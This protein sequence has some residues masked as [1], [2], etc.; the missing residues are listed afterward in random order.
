M[1]E[2]EAAQADLKAPGMAGWWE[3][4]IPKLSDEQASSL[5]SAAL[6]RGIAHRSISVV[7][8][9]WGFTVSPQQVGHWRRT[10]VG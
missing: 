9:Q 7:L 4:V 5:N 8:G 10:H 6:S 1:D 3:H 2:F